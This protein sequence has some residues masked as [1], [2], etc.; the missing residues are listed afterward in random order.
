AEQS[1]VFIEKIVS[2]VFYVSKESTPVSNE[3][4]KQNFEDLVTKGIKAIENKEFQKVVLSRKETMAMTDLDIEQVM[5]SLHFNYSNAFHYCFYHPKIGMWIGATPE[6]FLQVENDQVKTV[7]LAGTQLFSESL[8]WENK[9]KEEQQFVT[10]FIV[11]SLNLYAQNTSVSQ[12]YTFKA[13]T[14]AHIKSDISANLNS[15]NDFG[16]LIHL[17]HP[18]PAVCGLPKDA[19]KQFIIENENYNRKFYTGFLGELNI[20]FRTFKKENSDLFVNLRCME[21]ENNL[22]T[23]YV[24]CGITKDSIPEKEYIETVNKTMTMRKVVNLTPDL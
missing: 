15:K 6:Q 13:G 3:S 11:E 1:D 5:S 24:G 20:D 17:L 4:E 8:S 7:A 14:I 2:D 12:P 19:A 21:I 22:A 10:D 16:K 9:E 23:I 18:T